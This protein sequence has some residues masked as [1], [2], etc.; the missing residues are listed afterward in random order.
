[1][2][3]A[4]RRFDD[5]DFILHVVSTDLQAYQKLY[6]YRLS[7]LP[8]VQ[9]LPPTLVMKTIVQNRSLPP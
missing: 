2:I 7:R 5:A 8:S 6:D 3:Q 1:M 9:R 4:Q